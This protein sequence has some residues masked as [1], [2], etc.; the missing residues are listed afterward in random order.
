MREVAS[1]DE[2]VKESK[3]CAKRISA[4]E[5]LQGGTS[6]IEAVSVTLGD[7]DIAKEIE[8]E[9]ECFCE[10]VGDCE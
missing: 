7:R 8:V 10:W 6:A 2:W 5:R 9:G 3:T 1:I 4:Q